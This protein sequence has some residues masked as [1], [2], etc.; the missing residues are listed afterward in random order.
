[1]WTDTPVGRLFAVGARENAGAG[2]N[3]WVTGRDADAVDTRDD[4]ALAAWLK[5]E[6]KRL[7][8]ST[9][10]EF[11]VHRV[12]SWQRDPLHRGAYASWPPG[13]LTRLAPTAAAPLGRI[14]FAGEH[15]AQFMSGI[16]GAL[17]SGERA[18]L[19]LAARLG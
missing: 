16:E 15:T 3:C 12:V 19:E 6:L 1:M 5:G 14:H 4:A 7:R 8:P 18:M 9:N 10:G 17:E 13:Y 2:L 11:G